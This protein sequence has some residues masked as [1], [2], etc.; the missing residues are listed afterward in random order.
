LRVEVPDES[1]GKVPC[2]LRCTFFAAFFLGNQVGEAGGDA[3][4]I[5]DRNERFGAHDSVGIIVEAGE[6]LSF[7]AVGTV[8]AIERHVLVTG[9][10][11]EFIVAQVFDLV[12]VEADGRI[13]ADFMAATAT[14]AQLAAD[15]M[16]MGGMPALVVE[17]IPDDAEVDAFLLAVE[18]TGGDKLLKVMVFDVGVFVAIELALG[19]APAELVAHE[20]IGH[21][22]ADVEAFVEAEVSTIAIEVV[23]S[24]EAL[25][26]AEDHDFLPLRP[27]D[28][29]D[30]ARLVVAGADAENFFLGAVRGA[31]AA[32]LARLAAGEAAGGVVASGA[33]R[34]ATAWAEHAVAAFAFAAEGVVAAR[35]G[36]AVGV[37]I[38]AAD[39]SVPSVGAARAAHDGLLHLVVGVAG[40]WQLF[41]L[42][43]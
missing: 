40:H 43:L 24:F 32:W 37:V 4:A 11:G 31:A 15:L 25:G 5:A 2:F 17:H 42:G 13:E 10:E 3:E 6:N 12:L 19:A 41:G 22:G 1:D 38:R 14:A 39:W 26:T 16:E 27:A 28:L 33:A 36:V 8:H 30:V 35:T 34:A 9:L 29:H 23:R 7:A 18:Q 20:G 21:F